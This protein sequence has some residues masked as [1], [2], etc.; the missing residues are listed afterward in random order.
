MTKKR[1][2][3]CIFIVMMMLAVFTACGSGTETAGDSRTKM[4][5]DCAGRTVEIPYEPQRVA[6]LYASTAHMMAMLDEGDKI[7]GAPNGVK[8]DVLMQMK[9][10]QI[11]DTAT[12]YQEGSINIE[13]LARI[14]A[15]LALV[16]YSTAENEGETEKLDDLGIP[17]VVVDYTTMDELE[18]AI[19]VMGQVFGREDKAQEYIKFSEDTVKMVTDRLAD[20]PEESRPDVYHSVNEAIR[21][22]GEGDICSEIMSMAAVRNV[23]AEN[24]VK[25]GGDKTYVT[26]EEIYRWD[27]DAFIDNESSVTEYIM[28]DSKWAGLSAVKNKAVYTL[29][30]GATRWCHPG[31]MEA[32]MGVLAVAVQFYPD[33]FSDIDMK[34]YTA[35]YYERFF[36]LQLDDETVEKILSGEGMR[37]SNAPVK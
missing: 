17:Y 27:P 22:D 26:L 23:A 21:T 32:H 11:V 2:I 36:G 5:T 13:E 9:Y 14:E 16:R 33:R 15:D 35:E 19:D 29:P 12:P 30:V 7:V 37:V 18:E 4:V 8:S 10:P 34:S 24:G 31:S 1:R 3:S 28:T 6:C 25:T 20:V